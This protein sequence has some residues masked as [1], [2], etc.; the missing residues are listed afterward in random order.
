MA[1]SAAPS[2][3]PAAA[4]DTSTPVV[5]GPAAGL[6]ERPRLFSALERGSAGPVT[7]LT[8][9]AGSGKTM[10]LASWLRTVRPVPAVAWVDVERDERD[11]T[12]FWATVMDG[13]RRSGALAPG[14]P[15]ATLMPGPAGGGEFLERLAEGLGRLERP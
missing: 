1:T 8:G 2:R 9:P 12:R 13:V 15:L 3:N 7:L 11:A 4:G 5:P 10:L 14:D 6:V